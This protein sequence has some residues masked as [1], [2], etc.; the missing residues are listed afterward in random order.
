[1]TS[2]E[3]D[4]VAAGATAGA[5][6]GEGL[7]FKEGEELGFKSGLALGEQLGS[8]KG[9]VVA[10][11]HLETV[12]PNFCSARASASLKSLEELINS[13]PRCNSKDEDFVHALARCKAKHKAVRALLGAQ[14][15]ES[16]PPE[17]LEF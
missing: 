1:M 16:K 4:I 17:S 11:R 10:W 3:E 6:H 5:T 15:Q 14:A 7:G 8:I 9:D 12:D 2:F 13:F